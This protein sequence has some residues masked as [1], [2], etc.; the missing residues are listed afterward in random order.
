M[1]SL[2]S[3]LADLGIGKGDRVAIFAPNCWEYVA[4]FYAISWIGATVSHPEPFVP[5]A[6]GGIPASG[7]AAPKPSSWLSPYTLYLIPCFPML[8]N[9]G[10]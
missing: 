3:S 7:I 8:P 6:G 1:I 4:S 9:F 2:A 10:I 5:G